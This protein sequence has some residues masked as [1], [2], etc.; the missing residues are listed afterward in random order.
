MERV[1]RVDQ[2][3]KLTT[4]VKTDEGF[5]QVTAPIARVGVYRYRLADGSIQRE[6][7]PEETLF[8]KDSMNTLQM[9]PITNNHPLDFVNA[10]NAASVSVGMVGQTFFRDGDKLVTQFVV[11]HRKGIDAIDAGRDELSPGYE[12]DLDFTAGV[13]NEGEHYDCI[14]VNRVYNH[15]A[16]VDNARGGRDITLRVDGV[17][18]NELT[19]TNKTDGGFTMKQIHIDGIPYEAVP[20][21]ANHIAKLESRA[22]ALQD[23]L[24]S[25][26]SENS[27]LQGKCDAAMDE[28][29]KLKARLTD[30]AINELIA[31]RMELVTTATK[32]CGE[33]KIDATDDKRAIMEKVILAVAPSATIKADASD[34]YIAGRYEMALAI[35]ADSDKEAGNADQREALHND[36]T[37]KKDARAERLNRQQNAWKGGK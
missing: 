23:D 36:G 20:E 9:K 8:N 16:L 2:R 21:V 33:G 10:D 11:S 4:V 27:T 13:T 7:I 24:S 30:S 15:L 35:H 31:S 6:Y 32:I 14:Q 28:V 26:K 25:A 3:S 22:D 29:E 18:E 17:E 34:D 37:Q 1:S 19:V 5:L 12:C